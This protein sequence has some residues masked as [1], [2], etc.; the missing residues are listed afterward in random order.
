MNR[1]ELVQTI[2]LSADVPPAQ[3]KKTL[4]AILAT[5]AATLDKGEFVSIPDFGKFD[6]RL[7][8]PTVSRNPR[9]NTAITIPAEMRVTFAAYEQLRDSLN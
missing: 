9:T 2:A 3:A 4:D 5:I 8:P 6:V 1:S 7:D